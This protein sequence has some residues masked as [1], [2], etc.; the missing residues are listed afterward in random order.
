MLRLLVAVGSAFLLTDGVGAEP[1]AVANQSVM[2]VSSISSAGGGELWVAGSLHVQTS[3]R[4]SGEVGVKANLT[5]SAIGFGL[6]A[7][8]L[9][10]GVDEIQA[11]IGEINA[12][13]ARLQQQ[14]A[15]AEQELQAAK[16]T[17]IFDDI[18]GLQFDRDRVREAWAVI[19][20]LLSRIAA[21]K[22]ELNALLEELERMLD[23]FLN[24]R[25]DLITLFTPVGADAVVAA[26]CTADLL[27]ESVVSFELV[28]ADGEAVPF[29]IRLMLE[30]LEDG[31]LV[32]TDAV[33][34]EMTCGSDAGSCSC[35]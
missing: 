12:E 4:S 1:I 3:V 9:L 7:P 25:P 17:D 33:A 26:G 28:T 35:S 19:D 24:S 13:L 30:F 16:N 2:L 23:E 31:T 10:P 20:Q 27:C 29:H 32:P 14:L 21:L 11:R 34:C 18:A 8:G 5:E 22:Q 15:T 6:A